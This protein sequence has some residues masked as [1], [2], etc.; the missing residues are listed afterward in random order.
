MP[1]ETGKFSQWT[2]VKPSLFDVSGAGRETIVLYGFI[3]DGRLDLD[4]L[5]HAW[6]KMCLAWPILTARLRKGHKS[7]RPAD[8]HYFIPPASELLSVIEA[9]M[10]ER[11]SAS[12]RSL[13]FEKIRSPVREY[14]P[15]AEALGLPEDRPSVVHGTR[16]TET[17]P[18]TRSST[19]RMFA[20]NAPLTIRHLFEEDRPVVTAKIM[21]FTDATSIGIAVPHVLADGPGAHEIIKAWASIANGRAPNIEPLAKLGQDCFA[22]LAPGGPQATEQAALRAR[23]GQAEIPAPPGWRAFNFRQALAFGARFFWDVLWT[24]PERTMENREVYLPPHYI[25]EVKAAVLSELEIKSAVEKA[26]FVSTSDIVTAIVLKKMCSLDARG[27]NDKRLVSFLYPVNLR[28]QPNAAE[29]VQLPSPYLHN[30]VLPISLPEQ[31]IG[32]LVHGLSIA[33]VALQIR[34][35]LQRESQPEAIRRGLIWRLANA[36]KLLLFFRPSSFWIAGTNWRAMKLYDV[37]FEGV[38]DH[39]VSQ[40]SATGRT[41]KV[42]NQT[43]ADTPVRNVFCL[44]GDDPAGGIWLNM[45][46]S[47]SQWDRIDF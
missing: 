6:K 15:F 25:D 20:A 33:D 12:K 23:A 4:I 41:L 28:W 16:T 43:I 1:S 31:P 9:D 21:R 3:L 38:L 35:A 19:M 22:S 10:S 18:K 14:R 11:C 24:R 40:P 13:V 17:K 45:V 32:E 47:Q 7:K 44:T 30:A 8:W 37:S 5:Q 46:L 34:R 29:F 2:K 42:W 36:H 27:P 39:S 26:E